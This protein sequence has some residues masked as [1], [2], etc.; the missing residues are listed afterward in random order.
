[1]PPWEPVTEH[2]RALQE[3]AKRLVELRKAMEHEMQRSLHL[4]PDP[5]PEAPARV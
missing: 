2:D 5:T 3:Y 1:V 4:D